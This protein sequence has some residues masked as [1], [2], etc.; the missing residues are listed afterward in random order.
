G[1]TD[2]TPASFAWTI[3]SAAPETTIGT[4]PSNPSSSANASFTFSSEAGATFECALDAGAYAGCTSP[5]SYT[6]LADGSHSFQVRATDAAGNLDASPAGFTWTIDTAAPDTT[7]DTS[8]PNASS[9]GSASFTF[10]AEAGA[11]FECALDGGAYAACTSPKSYTGLADGS[12]TF[13]VR[14]KDAAGNTDATPASF[15][16][17]IDSTAP[18]TTIGASPANPSSSGSADFS[19][20]SEAGAT[21]ECAL[22]AGAFAAC[23]SPKSYTGLTD[24]SHTFQVRAKD[25][26]GNTDATPA[27]FTWTIDSTAPETTIGSQ[28]SSPSSSAGADF[29]FSSEAGATFECALDAGGF[30]PC[31]SPKSY[32]GLADGL[33]TFSVRAKDAAGNTDATPAS[34]AWT[35]DTTAP[36]TTIGTGPS[37]PSTSG[38]AS[39]SFSSEAG[40]SFEC[41]LDGAA[42][43]ACTS[44]HGYTGLAD[45]SHTFQVRA[46][47][48]AGNTDATPA[49][50]T[51]TID[52]A[53]P[54]TT[55]GASP[56]NP[57]SSANASFSFSSEAGATFECAIDAG[58]YA[59]CTS[60]HNYTTLADGSH[61]FQVRA[62]DAAG[63]TDATPASFTWTID[64]TAPETTIGTGPSNPSTSGSASFSFSSEAGASFECALDAGA[65]AAC[66]SPHGYTSLADGS[67]TFQVRAKDAAGNTDASPAASTWT[68]D[69]AAPDTTITAGPAATT[70]SGSASFSFSSEAG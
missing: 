16:W 58:A 69:S 30:A 50:S 45:G 59:T 22:D 51:W 33:H 40:A 35:I 5:H 48:A 4:Q 53:A 47:D 26:A 7:I 38:S 67:H 11:S 64:S 42:Y 54:E 62:K 29:T 36:D 9:S 63:N 46:K 18:E 6:A 34:F 57:S 27:S 21:F 2:A 25:A 28:P 52:S 14:A 49:A 17:T 13:Q 31:A 43:A 68:I 66:I 10:S 24:G 32:T 65:F 12:H 41:A 1:N 56:T 19:F 39:F 20:S 44:P 61:T 3:D 37:N 70:N 55:I 8:P 15:T 60:P 23:T